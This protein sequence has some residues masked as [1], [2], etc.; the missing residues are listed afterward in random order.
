MQIKTM[1]FVHLVQK[2]KRKATLGYWLQKGDEV[3]SG[4]I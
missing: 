3:N 4:G 1:D 2:K